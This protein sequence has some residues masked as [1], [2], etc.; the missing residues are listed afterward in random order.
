MSQE[1]CLILR[2]HHPAGRIVGRIDQHRAGTGG[3]SREQGVE[4]Q[5]PPLVL[6]VQR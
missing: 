3:K 1:S 6:G 2:T 4:I 5:M